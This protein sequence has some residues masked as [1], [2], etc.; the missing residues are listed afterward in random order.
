T[1]VDDIHAVVDRPLD[2]PDK[3]VPRRAQRFAEQFQDVVVGVGSLLLNGR[4]YCSPMAKDIFAGTI[5]VFR[6]EGD[7]MRWCTNVG[8]ARVNACVDDGDFKTAHL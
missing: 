8:V 6:I 2:G 3:P 1:E 7:A 5:A 4:G